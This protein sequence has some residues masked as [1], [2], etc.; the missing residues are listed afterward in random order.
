MPR[1]QF[2]SLFCKG[3]KIDGVGLT[4]SQFMTVLGLCV[5]AAVPLRN[6]MT[7]YIV[8]SEV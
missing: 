6:L 3:K 1:S 4:V 7:L 2:L 5:E 8:S